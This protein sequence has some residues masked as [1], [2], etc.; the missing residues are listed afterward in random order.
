[1]LVIKKINNNAAVCLDGSGREL[2][3]FGKGIGFPAIPYE[4]T[5]LQKVDRTFYDINQQYLMLLKDIPV[6]VVNFTARMMDDIRPQLPYEINP[7]TTLILADHIAFALERAQKGVY[8]RMPSV[9]ELE[10]S[11]PL[12]V[13]IGR[14]FVSAMEKEF[15]ARLPKDEIQGIA[16]HFINV[17]DNPLSQAETR[18]ADI[19]QKFDEV[20]EQTTQIIE[21]QMGMTVRRDTFNYAR[22]ATHVQYLLERLF[23]KKHID[24]DNLQMYH[25]IRVEYPEISACADAIGE[26]YRDNWS[27]TLTEEEK[28]Y[29]ILHI[30]RVCAAEDQ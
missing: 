17:R 7:N 2:V 27:A 8:I 26:Y 25:S 4:L 29:L 1:M 14:R 11:H 5:D 22:F 18:K 23:E 3:A 21:R 6:E 16:M 13:K 28:L 10:Q 30:N 9:Y 24:S 19:Q 12:E 20:L 15:R